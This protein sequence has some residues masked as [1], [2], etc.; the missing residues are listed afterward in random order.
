MEI[1]KTHVIKG[2]NY[3]SIRHKNL[4][5]IKLDIKEFEFFP[6]NMIPDF[7]TNLQK[8]LPSLYSHRCSEGVP[9][10]FFSRLEEGTWLGH[11]IEHVALEMQ[12]L[13]G[14]DCGFGRTLSTSRQ[15]VYNV[16]FTYLDEECGLYAGKKAIELVE[17]LAKGM[18]YLTLSE[19]LETL[20]HYYEEKKLGP[21]TQ[22]IFDEAAKRNIPLKLIPGSSLLTLGQGVYQKKMWATVS[23]QTSAIGIDITSNKDLTKKI[24][25]ENYIPTPEGLI[26]YNLHDL[27]S[28]ILQLKF[29]LVIK[30]LNSNHGK[31]ITTNIKTREQ[32]EAA[33]HFATNYGRAVIIERF[34][35][36]K[37]YR[38]LVINYKVVAVAE[39]TSAFIVG[40]GVATIQQLI[41]Q[42]NAD[43]RRGH[44]HANLL[45]RIEIDEVTLN[46][47]KDSQLTPESILP[48]GQ[49]QFLK[50]TANISSGGTASDLTDKVH[51][52]N[53]A[54]AERIARLVNMD[55]CGIDIIAKDIKKPLT[56]ENGSV[57][58]VNASPGLRMHLSPYNGKSRNVAANILN[59]LY[60]PNVPSRIPLIAVT[61]TNG[62]TTV[63]QL[64]AQIAKQ[65][66]CVGHATTEGIYS[67][68]H[69]IYEG[70]CSG[71]KSARAVLQDPT[72]NFAVLECARGG[73][74]RE[75][76][77]FDQCDISILTNISN[78]HLGIND[79]DSLEKM[80]KLK[81][82][83]LE[84]THANGF[85][86][87][88][89][90]DDIVYQLKD[91]LKSQV[92]LFAVK[93][94][95]RI[96]DHCDRGGC[97]IYLDKEDIILQ[98]GKTR[99]RVASVSVF[100]GIRGIGMVKNF[101][102]AILAAHLA[103]F[104]VPQIVSAL[105]AF[106]SDAK[107]NPGRMNLFTW[108]NT[109]ILLDYA[110]NE[111]AYH[112]LKAYMDNVHAAKKVGIITGV[113]DRRDADIEAIGYLS[114]QMF[115]EIII[116]HNRDRR[117]RSNEDITR[118]LMA[119][120]QRAKPDLPVEV[121]SD[122]VKALTYAIKG[123]D[124]DT[125]IYHCIDDVTTALNFMKRLQ[126]SK[127]IETDQEEGYYNA[128][129][130]RETVNHWWS[131]R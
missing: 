103:D 106:N 85:A 7:V 83:V 25:E 92:A 34:I 45:T 111:G 116:R 26:I 93:E 94:S 47:L 95:R 109:R 46:V 12:C 105:S 79:I 17:S 100:P 40:N 130:K 22:A 121:I 1:L 66:H 5:V 29:P 54:M 10:G 50:Y 84:T 2:P 43:P 6:S 16:L 55:I 23:S 14:M 124:E 122:E 18:P 3:W 56:A 80:A 44:G 8:I 131:G 53:M 19:D 21:S 13:A 71:P 69:L 49:M 114:G 51:K 68:G 58:E 126:K 72:I 91:N 98:N 113:G 64:L 127:T 115:D 77:G 32:A 112:E 15:G 36:G 119:G 37:D 107:M 65:S 102:C 81:S 67:N 30:P 110:H 78:D 11:V 31:G 117:G 27:N 59:M 87:L 9:G 24:L 128:E 35:K 4:I 57:L 73:I 75:G 42:I 120:I 52:N 74:L 86:I 104:P 38:F 118:L 60:P 125:F 39:R 99:K 70:D 123:A 62:K 33:F 41:E 96:S 76:L 97:A 89:A 82:V 48:A 28:A 61:G 63:V 129:T 20:R 108:N 90:D 88:N 101:L